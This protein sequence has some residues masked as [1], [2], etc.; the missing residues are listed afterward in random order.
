MKTFASLFTGGGGADLGALEA[1][2]RP[3]WG[4]EHDPKIVRVAQ[5]NGLEVL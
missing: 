1:G 3:I 2:L 4:I 5:T